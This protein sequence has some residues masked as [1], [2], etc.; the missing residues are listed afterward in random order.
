MRDTPSISFDRIAERYDATRGGEE[1][2]EQFASDLADLLDPSRLLL[3]VGVGTGVISLA[4]RKRGFDV[5]GVDISMEMLK[6]ARERLVP[7]VAQA[8][9]MVLPV[10][11]SSVDQVVCVW[12]LHCVGDVTTTLAEIARALR[13]GGR[14]Y[15]VDGKAHAHF[16]AADEAYRAIEQGLGIEPRM[17]RVHTYAEIAAGTALEVERIVDSGPHP[18]EMS[19]AHVVHN[20]ESRCHSYMWDVPDDVWARVSGPVIDRLRTRPDLNDER[21]VEGW[22]EIL[23]LRKPEN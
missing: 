1:R 4:L 13:P 11:D 7:R 2:G 22:Q 6:R 9:A 23:V 15:V 19:L 16:E 5:A 10:G 14:C 17:G 12:V 20:L 18:H 21:I 3:E 8:D